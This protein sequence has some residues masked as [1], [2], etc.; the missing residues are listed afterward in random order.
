MS[1][2]RYFLLT[3][4]GHTYVSSLAWLVTETQHRPLFKSKSFALQFVAHRLVNPS[5]LAPRIQA[6]TFL[7]NAH[8]HYVYSWLRR[9][10]LSLK[11]RQFKYLPFPLF[12]NL[13]SPFLLQKH[14][15]Y[16]FT[17]AS[18]S[19]LPF[20]V[21]S[22]PNPTTRISG[23]TLLCIHISSPVRFLLVAIDY[24]CVVRRTWLWWS[25]NMLH[26]LKR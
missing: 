16:L 1:S 14:N 4:Q 24:W 11:T 3:K 7:S 15:L 17:F 20:F 25:M 13:L 9:T 10:V 6:F 2:F 22:V 12:C 18:A 23:V 21:L 5:Y 8:T 26:T 19:F